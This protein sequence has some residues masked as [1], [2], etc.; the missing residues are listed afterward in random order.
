MWCDI[1]L[2]FASK[3]A[4]ELGQLEMG[5]PAEL[6]DQSLQAQAARFDPY[7]M[8]IICVKQCHKPQKWLGDGKHD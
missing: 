3:E 7:S 2:S 4:T 8:T 5:S 6:K 1:L